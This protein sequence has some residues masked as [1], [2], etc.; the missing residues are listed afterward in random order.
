[1]VVKGGKICLRD[2]LGFFVI[3][4]RPFVVGQA[5]RSWILGG[6]AHLIVLITFWIYPYS[7][8]PT[9]LTHLGHVAA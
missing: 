7:L 6:V 9:V 5:I 3:V 2:Q 8:S 1:M 4:L